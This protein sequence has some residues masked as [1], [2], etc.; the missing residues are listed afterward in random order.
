MNKQ[1]VEM[2]ICVRFFVYLHFIAFFLLEIPHFILLIPYG[3]VLFSNLI[4]FMQTNFLLSIFICI[5]LCND[6]HKIMRI[7]KN[8]TKSTIHV[9]VISI[10]TQTK[11]NKYNVCRHHY[12]RWYRFICRWFDSDSEIIKNYFRRNKSNRFNIIHRFYLIEIVWN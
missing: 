11:Q 5:G 8:Q 9:R 1:Q 10:Q 4:D 12:R 7:N 2:L 3:F 6:I